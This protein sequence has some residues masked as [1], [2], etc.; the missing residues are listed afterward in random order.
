MI[1][2]NSIPLDHSEYNIHTHHCDRNQNSQTN[3]DVICLKSRET[4]CVRCYIVICCLTAQFLSTCTAVASL[5][6]SAASLSDLLDAADKAGF[7][8][9]EKLQ[10][11]R[12]HFE[13]RIYPEKTDEEI[14]DFMVGSV[15]FLCAGFYI[16]HIKQNKD[17]HTFIIN[18]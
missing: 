8:E 16:S 18:F 14:A 2:F 5:L 3:S 17:R 12:L 6:D 7:T 9:G 10:I 15:F 4:M 1:T 11:K 13:N